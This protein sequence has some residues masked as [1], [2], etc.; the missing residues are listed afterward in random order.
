MKERTPANLVR[1][2]LMLLVGL[3][4]MSLGVGFSIKA[5]LGTSPVSSVP[6]VLS[7]DITPLT[8]GQTTILFNC[9][10]VLLQIVLLRRRFQLV[11][12]V[13][14]PVAMAF[15]YLCDFSVWLLQSINPTTY[16]QQWIFCIA[17]ILLVGTGV[18]FE[19]TADVVTM[20][21]EGVALALCKVFKLKFASAKVC[22]D[23]SMVLIAVVLGFAF[24]HR[25]SGVREGT[26]AA[27]IFVGIT[28]RQVNKPM[29][30]VGAK[31]LV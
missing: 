23:C 4:I 7:D 21:G 12:L 20:A 13:Q 31:L 25:L 27:A 16:W 22:V 24:L 30:H 5:G 19:V 15:G 18:S 6:Y 8:V 2:Y 28:S 3:F 1:R 11:Q 14:V 17:G 29:K 26:V 10:L 9:C